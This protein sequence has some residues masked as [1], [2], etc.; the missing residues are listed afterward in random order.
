MITFLFILVNIYIK[1]SSGFY[2]KFYNSARI[3]Q[4]YNSKS[5]ITVSQGVDK[6]RIDNY[7][8][9][10]SPHVSRSAFGILCDSGKV[11]LNNKIGK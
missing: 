11:F 1:F 2:N 4:L 9:S 6:E 5:S 7:L 10:L 3:T 8:A